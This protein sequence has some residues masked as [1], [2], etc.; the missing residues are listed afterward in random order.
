[1]HP[2]YRPAAHYDVDIF[3]IRVCLEIRG[4]GMPPPGSYGV[5]V[6]GYAARVRGEARVMEPDR[7]HVAR[8]VVGK[9]VVQLDGIVRSGTSV[10][11]LLQGEGGD[12]VGGLVG[13]DQ[14]GVECVE[15]AAGV[16]TAGLD[17]AVG[18][19]TDLTV[20]DPV[21]NIEARVFEASVPEDGTAA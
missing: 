21:A 7:T 18:G 11:R 14:G 19:L 17:D 10:H 12:A 6:A 9:L 2:R 20:D 16:G 15:A 5:V 4:Q 8:V 3:R 1:M 13:L